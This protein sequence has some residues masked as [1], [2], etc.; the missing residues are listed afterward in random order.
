MIPSVGRIVH[1]RL[2]ATCA[3]Q[4]NKR[5]QDARTS[6]VARGNSGVVVHTGNP[7]R[8]GDIVPMLICKVWS[9]PRVLPAADCAV[10][11]QAF[12]DGNDTLWV[13]S[14]KQGTLPGQ[15]SDPRA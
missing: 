2:T 14:A 4:V 3:E 8:E 11:G 13:T 15:W 10:N 9:Q 5:R 1:L 12:L 7:A 6:Q